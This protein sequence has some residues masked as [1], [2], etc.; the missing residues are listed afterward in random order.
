MGQPVRIKALEALEPTM[1]G[2]IYPN[3]KGTYCIPNFALNNLATSVGIILGNTKEEHDRIILLV[4]CVGEHRI[5]LLLSIKSKNCP[6]PA[7]STGRLRSGG[8]LRQRCV[9][10]RSSLE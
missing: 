7:C 5:E 9:T 3:E 2:E 6:N 8:N 4:K 1:I 10:G